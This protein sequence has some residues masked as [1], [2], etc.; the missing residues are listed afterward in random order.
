MSKDYGNIQG[1]ILRLIS[2][3]D[4]LSDTYLKKSWQRDQYLMMAIETGNKELL[5]EVYDILP[6][7]GTKEHTYGNPVLE[8][9][10]RQRKNGLII[11]N[12]LCR[13]GAGRGGVPPRYLHNISE[14]YILLIERQTSSEELMNSIAPMMV[15]EYMDLVKHSSVADYSDLIKKVVI[16]VSENIQQPL[17]LSSVAGYFHVNPS[18]LSREFKK[19]TG[20]NITDYINRYKIELAKLYL[21]QNSKSITEVSDLL[22]YNSSSYFSKTFKKITGQS[23][24]E[25]K[26][27]FEQTE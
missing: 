20:Y 2:V 11:R 6:P 24:S 12:T 4:E 5:E 19:E 27:S 21:V 1:E 14:K 26:N 18:H 7:V 15:E 3:N 10:L 13:V 23:P 22:N 9:E 16:Y 17:S 25:Y 8:D